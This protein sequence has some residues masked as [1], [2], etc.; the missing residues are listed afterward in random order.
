MGDLSTELRS[1]VDNLD[2]NPYRVLW[3]YVQATLAHCGGNQSAAARRLGMH[4]RTL[5]RIIERR[6]QPDARP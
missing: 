4:R 2:A 1:A 3:L 6:Y 5:Q